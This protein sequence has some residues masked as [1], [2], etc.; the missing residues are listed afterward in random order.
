VIFFCCLFKKHSAALFFNDKN[1]LI[2]LARL[3]Q[4][5]FMYIFFRCLPVT[6]MFL[7][8]SPLAAQLCTGSLGDPVVNVTFGTGG[9]SNTGYIPTSAYTYSSTACPDDGY[10]TITN[11]TSGCFGN[12]WITVNSDH[13]GNGAFLLVNATY[14]PGDFLVTRVTDLCPNTTYEF[15]AWIMNV[16]ARNA[17][18]PNI[19]FRIE[20]I[21]GTVLQEFSTGDIPETFSPIWKQYGFFFSTPVNNPEIVLRMTNNAP[22][23]IGN[24]I[25]MDDITFRPCGSVLLTSAIQG[26]SNIVDICKGNTNSYDFTSTVTAGYTD[27]VYQWQLSTDSGKIWKDIPGAGSLN[28]FRS[29]TGIGAY[30][31]RLSVT[32]KTS[33]AIIACR[34][35][36]NNVIINVHPPPIVSAGADRIIITG[37]TLNLSGQVTGE[38]P[39]YYWN[40]P[41]YLSDIKITDPLVT[42]L[43]S[44]IYTLYA[45]SA[46]GCKNNDAVS[47]KVVAGI[48]VPT[49]FTP[50]NDGRNDS[51]RIPFLDPLFGAAT[52][53][54]NRYGQL[55]YH[56]EGI[57]VDW[58]GTYKKLPQPAGTYVYYIHFKEQYKDMKGTLTLIR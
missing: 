9:N 54:Y 19:T 16:M 44:K 24:D 6:L 5:I 27:P 45:E 53:V 15:A 35:A 18:K 43:E 51:W 2:T 47:I 21:G 12:S 25:A 50:N 56:A 4:T 37:N 39:T 28:Y 7:F 11:S 34:I 58:D 8:A 30:W 1:K 46:Y 38:T 22:G 26:N 32:E 57:A 42:P 17:I 40:P 20:T 52:N 13:T 48:F 31:Y 33:A 41:D 55:V 29:P 3:I 49:A 10:Y 14:A 36:S 23:G